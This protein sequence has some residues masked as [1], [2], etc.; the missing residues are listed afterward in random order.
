MI[1][2][3]LNKAEVHDSYVLAMVHHNKKQGGGMQV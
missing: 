2:I 1:I 3:K